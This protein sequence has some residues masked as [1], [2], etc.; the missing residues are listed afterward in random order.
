MELKNQ[1]VVIIGGSSGI[2]LATASLALSY[3]ANVTIAAR[4]QQK[5]QQSVEKLGSNVRSVV[6]DIMD[7]S[8]V[9]RIFQSLERVDHLFV[10]AGSLEAGGLISGASIEKLKHPI[11]ER[12]YGAIYAVRHA[13]PKM[14]SG[15]I[16]LMSGLFSTR[17]MPGSATTAAAVAGIEAMARTM[18]LELSPIRVNAVC[19]GYID[20]PLLAN[21]F[22]ESYQQIIQSQAAT[23]PA[24]RVGSAQ[25][26][27][28]SVVFMMT[29]GFMTGEILHIDG[30][31][32]LV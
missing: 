12:I 17:P 7:E 8:Q 10:A 31:G 32:R 19:P 4:N 6:A 28:Q 26:V 27:A 16:T 5:L 2:G 20:T 23:L 15:S 11:A 25:E 13:V 18:A 9:E 24:K 1:Q 21:A 3:G 14:K 29:N 22:G 30:G